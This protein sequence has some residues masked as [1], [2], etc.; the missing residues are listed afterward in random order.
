MSDRQPS[1]M[2][3]IFN[4]YWDTFEGLMILSGAV[5]SGVGFHSQATVGAEC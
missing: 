4:S 3:G 1:Q 5:S 2:Q